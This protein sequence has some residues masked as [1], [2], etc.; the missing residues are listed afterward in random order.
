[1]KIYL[2]PGLGFDDRIFRNLTI[3][4]HEV[5]PINW[6]DPLN[7]E[8]IQSYAK[9]LS[10]NIDNNETN[11]LIGHSFGGIICQE[12]SALKS[13]Q[14]S[15]LI[16]SIKHCKE[17][18]FHFKM[19]KPTGLYKLFSKN[20]TAKTIKYWGN[21]YDY[22]TKE[23]KELVV[24]MVNKQS[25]NYLQWALKQLA[26][27]RKPESLTNNNL[28]QVHGDLDTTFPFR[29]INKPKYVI[30]NA[31]HFMVYKKPERIGEIINKEIAEELKL[32]Q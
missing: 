23:E 8:S 19:M 20:L 25:N 4:K 7:N 9:R 29:L 31:G 6:I 30:K 24:D 27:W 14:K 16:S 18:P 26:V 10:K 32:K 17:N 2:I 12:I 22:E 11:I 3:E 21:K 5:E 28:I 1:M 15:I 13:I